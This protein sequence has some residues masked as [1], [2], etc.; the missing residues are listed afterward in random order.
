[1]SHLRS[2]SLSNERILGKMSETISRQ[3]RLLE[4]IHERMCQQLESGSLPD[5]AQPGESSKVLPALQ[6]MDHTAGSLEIMNQSTTLTLQLADCQ[7][8]GL[9]CVC[10]CHHQ[11]RIRTSSRLS[12]ILGSL[13]I[14]YIALPEF[15][16]KCSTNSCLR[17]KPKVQLFYMFPQWFSEIAV[18]MNVEF[19]PPKGPELLLRCLRVRSYEFTE[20]FQ[21][22]SRLQCG[23][24]KTLVASRRASILDV[25]EWGSSLLYVGPSRI[26]CSFLLVILDYY[27]M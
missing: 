27:L 3:D 6:N 5:L 10:T 20:S 15:F 21:A 4:S 11:K 16:A 12:R 1:M 13:F 23:Q 9:D 7:R 26:S 14:G 2:S 18:Y 25:D 24:V 17:S 8:C 22:L 19:S